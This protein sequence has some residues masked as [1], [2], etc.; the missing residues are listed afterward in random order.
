VNP[1]FPFQVIEAGC[2]CLKQDINMHDAASFQRS[3]N[4]QSISMAA[5]ES[6]PNHSISNGQKIAD[7]N[8]SYSLGAKKF[9]LNSLRVNLRNR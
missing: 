6:H 9:I 4:N 7:Q 2:G 8:Q 1:V 5:N 3:N